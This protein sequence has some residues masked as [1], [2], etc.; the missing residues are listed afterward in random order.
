MK[1]ISG[2]NE[3][4]ELEKLL[5]EAIEGREIDCFYDETN[6]SRLAFKINKLVKM[7]QLKNQ[8]LEDDKM[9]VQELISD[10]SHQTKTPIANVLLYT[11]LLQDD[12][13]LDSELLEYV[14]VINYQ[15]EKLSFFIKTMVMASQLEMGIIQINKDIFSIRNLF[16][17]LYN[18][19]KSIA[20][21]NQI[22]IDFSKTDL[23]YK[24]DYRWTKEALTN[25]IDNSIKYSNSGTNIKVTIIE[26][27]LF[28]RIDVIDEG[29]GISKEEQ[30]EVF[31]RFYRGID[32]RLI[33]GFGIGLYLVKEIIEKQGGYLK[34]NSKKD[35]GT[36]VSIFLPI[37]I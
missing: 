2:R 22:E 37:E 32:T 5:D 1:L 3:Y 14:D 4:N 10:I 30:K 35:V 19:F 8:K 17:D 28:F 6:N 34:L 24:F 20:E 25:L 23:F 16:A 27:D 11:Q 7:Y 12:I 21:K 33:E 15:T 26:Y 9:R 29:I 13:R 31:K 18:S 36:T